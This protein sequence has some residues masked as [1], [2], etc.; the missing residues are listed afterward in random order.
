MQRGPGENKTT[1]L[2]SL[3]FADSLDLEAVR[4]TMGIRIY[5]D[6]GLARIAINEGVIEPDDDLLFPRF[7]MVPGL[8]DWLRHTVQSWMDTR[9]N[10]I[11]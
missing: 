3:S 10:W 9:P 1:V 11:K 6:T 4:I 5:P 8:D 7:Y 2:E